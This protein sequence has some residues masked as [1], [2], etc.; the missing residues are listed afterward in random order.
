MARMAAARGRRQPEQVQIMYGIAGE[1]RLTEWERA[2]AA[3]LTTTRRRCASAT[4]RTA[5]SSSTCSAR[6]WMRCTRRAAAASARA[7]TAGRCSSPSSSISRQS[8]REPD[9]GIWEVRSGRAALHLFQG[10][11]LGRLRSRHQERRGIRARRP[12]R[13][14]ARAAHADPRRGVPARASTRSC[15]SFVQSYGSKRARREPAAAAGG[16]LPAAARPA[17]HGTVAAIERRLL[18]DGFVQRYDTA[19]SD[20]GL[21]PGEGAFLACSFWLVDAYVMLGP[22][23]RCAARCSSG[24]SRSATTSAC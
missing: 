7:T 22:A 19:R 14:L 10:D 3:G 1:R 2:V 24:C 6:S 12:D 11:G 13:A 4:P 16:R 5:S 9:E 17:R 21:P 18:R 15:S 8:G 23:R 20:D